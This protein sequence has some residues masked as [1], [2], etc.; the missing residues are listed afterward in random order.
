MSCTL[1]QRLF[2]DFTVQDYCEFFVSLDF[3]L[4]LPPCPYPVVTL[5]VIAVAIPRLT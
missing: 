5:L 4:I 1:D 2:F 3:K